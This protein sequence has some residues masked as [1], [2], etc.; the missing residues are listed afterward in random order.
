MTA[1]VKDVREVADR[2]AGAPRRARAGH[3]PVP[4]RGAPVQQGAA[5]RAAA[6]RRRGAARA[7]RRD[8]REPVLLIDRPAALALHALP[9]RAARTGGDASSAAARDGRSAWVGRRGAHARRRGAGAPRRP[10]GGRRPSR[11]HVA[12]G[13]HGARGRV[14]TLEGDARGHRSRTRDACAP[15]RRRR[16]LRRA[17]GVHQEHQGLGPRRRPVLA[18]ADAR[19]RRGSSSARAPTRDP[20]VGGRRAGRLAGHAWSPTPPRAPWSSSGCRRRS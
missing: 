16:A 4:G 6:A 14:G 2:R 11:P 12:R 15:V 9:P 8:D 20:G 19:G 13:R 10:C 18:R 17:L 7:R 5:G 3:D 1:G